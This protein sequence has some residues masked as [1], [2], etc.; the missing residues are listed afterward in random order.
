MI[1]ALVLFLYSCAP[2][3]QKEGR[4]TD[5]K[6]VMTQLSL[7]C[8]GTPVCADSPLDLWNFY[9]IDAS[10]TV[11]Y[12]AR[13]FAGEGENTEI[14]LFEAK[15]KTALAKIRAALQMRLDAK[16]KELRQTAPGQY[17]LY[18]ESRVV[19]NGRFIRLLF[20][21]DARRLAGIYD[22]CFDSSINR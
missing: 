9:G 21:A 4:R 3:P 22:S 17:A 20:S 12:Q 7:Y 16:Q 18:R 13:S 6:D 15:D 11:Q 19:S 1:P 8:E 14:L 10:D 5:L 2:S